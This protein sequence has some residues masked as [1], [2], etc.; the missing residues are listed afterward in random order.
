MF[1]FFFI[2]VGFR[3]VGIEAWAEGAPIEAL[4][5]AALAGPDKDRARPSTK[6]Q[7]LS[8]PRVGVNSD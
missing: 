8:G 4:D 5:G 1:F 7:R 6:P 2:F 3:C